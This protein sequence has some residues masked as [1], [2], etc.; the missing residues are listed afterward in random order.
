MG[1]R[2]QKT[3]VLAEDG[4]CFYLHNPSVALGICAAVFLIIAQVFFAAVGGCCGFCCKPRSTPSKNNRIIGVVCA[5]FS[6]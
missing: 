5:V 6:W 4:V 3:D 1:S 2:S